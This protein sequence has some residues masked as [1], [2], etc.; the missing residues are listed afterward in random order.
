MRKTAQ[1]ISAFVFATQRVQNL[2]FLN[3]KFQGSSHLL[4]LCSPVCVGNP[5]ERL[6]NNE[7]QMK[8]QSSCIY[9]TSSPKGNDHS[10]ENKHF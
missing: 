4:W 3:P 10:P 2:F 5:E 7:A 9:G 8:Y 6:A 1:L